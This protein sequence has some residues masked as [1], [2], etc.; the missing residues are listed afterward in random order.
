MPKT[1]T[2]EPG[3]KDF[4]GYFDPKLYEWLKGRAR[5]NGQSLN[6]AVVSIIEKAMEQ[7]K[8]EQ[9]Q[10]DQVLSLK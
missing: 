4:H 9:R 10:H 2:Y 5:R 8:A 3:R 6:S 1:F 7:D